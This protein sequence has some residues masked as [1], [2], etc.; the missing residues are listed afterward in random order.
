MVRVT[1][2]EKKDAE[3]CPIRDVLDRVGDKWSI[4]IFCVLEDGDKRFNEIKRMLGD[5]T[6]RVLTSTLRKLETEGYLTREVFPTSPPKVSYGLTERGR[7][8]LELMKPVIEWASS[9][10]PDIKAD[11]AQA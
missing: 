9:A 2:L 5:I 4:L 7:T 1:V 11:R 6:Q 8:L 3:N 10:H